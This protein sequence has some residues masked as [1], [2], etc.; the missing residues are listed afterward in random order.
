MRIFWGKMENTLS[1]LFSENLYKLW[2]IF[3]GNFYKFW[4]N[5]LEEKGRIVQVNMFHVFVLAYLTTGFLWPT[6]LFSHCFASRKHE[7]VPWRKWVY[8]N[9]SV[10]T[11]SLHMCGVSRFV[12][13][14]FKIIYR[15]AKPSGTRTMF[16]FFLIGKK[17]KIKMRNAG[18]RWIN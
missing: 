10:Y 1:Y 18:K 12:F 5:M 11:V 8:C 7:C 15:Y 13:K 4:K 2:Q 6:L 16:L 17:K 9:A 3:C 14:I